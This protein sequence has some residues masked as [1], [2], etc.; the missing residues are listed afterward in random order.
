MDSALVSYNFSREDREEFAPQ[1]GRILDTL[2]DENFIE[3]SG[4][5]RLVLST[6]DGVSGYFLYGGDQRPEE[7]VHHNRRQAIALLSDPFEDF[8]LVVNPELWGR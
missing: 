5:T 7:G 3:F 8:A 2:N 1:V 6:L 4:G